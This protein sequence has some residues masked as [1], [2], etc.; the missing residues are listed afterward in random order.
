VLRVAFDLPQIQRAPDARQHR[1]AD[2]S[3]D[4]RRFESGRACHSPLASAG[5]MPDNRHM[6]A[7]IRYCTTEDSVRIA[8]SVEGDHA[9]RLF[10]VRWR[11][12]P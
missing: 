6:T 2:F 9:V 5:S 10:E 8:Y 7:S 3:S 12:F 11:E 4:G 1:R